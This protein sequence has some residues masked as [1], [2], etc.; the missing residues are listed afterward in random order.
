M[1]TWFLTS[2]AITALSGCVTVE[3]SSEPEIYS[4]PQEKAEARLALGMG[5]LQQGNMGK[6]RENLEKA[7]QHAPDFYRTQIS[8]AHYY[9]QVGEDDKARKLY[10]KAKSDHPSNGNVLNNYGTFLCKQGEYKEADELFN[11]A[12]AQP[13]YY[14]ISGSY[15]NA[16]FCALK[17]GDEL[18]AMD[19]FARAIDYEPARYRSTLNLAKL[20]IEHDKLLDAR[21]RLMKFSQMYGVKREAL[22]LMVA[23]EAK[24]G[25]QSLVEKYLN[26]LAAL[27]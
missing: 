27:G 6:A 4:N 15:E 17:S 12:I 3:T 16:A 1:K 24:A 9:E 14:Q 8:L 19:Y 26:Q 5:Y 18:K 11:K 23:L 25:N 13:Y 22:Q 21:I 2:L 7:M 20:E 10:K